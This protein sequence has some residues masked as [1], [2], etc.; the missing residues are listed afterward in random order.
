MIADRIRT[1]A[2]SEALRQVVQPSSVVLDIGTGTG[3]LP[4]WPVALVLVG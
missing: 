4:S 1:D 3:I 2:Y